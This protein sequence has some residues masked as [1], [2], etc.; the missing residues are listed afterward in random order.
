MEH[1]RYGQPADGAAARGN[2]PT[3]PA[4]RKGDGGYAQS[5]EGLL[6]Q[7]CGTVLGFRQRDRA[8]QR[9]FRC[10]CDWSANMTFVLFVDMLGFARLVET[11]GDDLSELNPIFKDIERHS[12]CA[13]AA[14][15]L[16]YRFVNFHR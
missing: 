16:Q 12:E 10:L 4:V 3:F 6:Q 1:C 5:P 7:G 2:A 9:R 8:S 13:P 15:L 14:N 11:E